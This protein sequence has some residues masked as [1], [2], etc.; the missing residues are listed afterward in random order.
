MPNS[1]YITSLIGPGLAAVTLSEVV[2]ADIWQGV[3]CPRL[4]PVSELLPGFFLC[5][6]LLGLLRT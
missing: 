2:N 5:S 6:I 4:S 1:K 3:T